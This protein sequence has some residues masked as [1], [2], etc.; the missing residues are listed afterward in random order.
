M[1]V[2]LKCRSIGRLWKTATMILKDLQKNEG[3]GM[4]EL[5]VY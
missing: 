2:R 1:H 3:S 5:N 4:L